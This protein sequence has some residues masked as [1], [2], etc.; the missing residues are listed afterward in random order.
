MIGFR[1]SGGGSEVSRIN[2]SLEPGLDSRR[3]SM[4]RGTSSGTETGGSDETSRTRLRRLATVGL[5][6][7][8]RIMGRGKSS[9]TETGGSKEPRRTR[10]RRLA[11]V[12]LDSR[13]CIDMGRGT[14]SGTETGG[15]KEH[16]R[17]SVCFPGGFT[18]IFVP[19]DNGDG[20]AG[21][22]GEIG[23]TRR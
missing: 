16:R 19:L 8:R 2:S 21:N 20:D 9:G 10:L 7:R 3:R 4:G 12:G 11:T 5:D 15:S 23:A 18:I 14:S 6:P 1:W 22:G 13:R 17:P